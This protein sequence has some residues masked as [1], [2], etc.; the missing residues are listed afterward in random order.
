MS[1]DII[2][3]HIAF[4]SS[5]NTTFCWSAKSIRHFKGKWLFLKWAE[6]ILST[7]VIHSPLS[8]QVR[9]TDSTTSWMPYEPVDHLEI[10]DC[11]CQATG[12]CLL[13]LSVDKRLQAS[14]LTSW[15]LTAD[16]PCRLAKDSHNRW[17]DDS[18][19]QLA[20]KSPFLADD[21]WSAVLVGWPRTA[22]CH[23]W[24]SPRE[25]K[26]GEISSH[27]K[28]VDLPCKSFPR[29]IFCKYKLFVV[30]QM[31]LDIY[32]YVVILIKRSSHIFV[33]FYVWVLLALFVIAFA[34]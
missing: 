27:Y 16:S 18:P 12:D 10:I 5:N 11:P 33:L 24:Q 22:N 26:K 17:A 9:S 20:T 19:C 31:D 1:S 34:F 6:V 21:S 2:K 32:W 13:S 30:K 28:I 7:Q 8:L 25:G 14:S 3:F 23:S 4:V 15:P 29:K